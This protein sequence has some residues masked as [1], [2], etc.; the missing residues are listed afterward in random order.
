MPA[1]IDVQVS[2]SQGRVSSQSLAQ[3]SVGSQTLAA[4]QSLSPLQASPGLPVPTDAQSSSG[5]GRA[6]VVAMS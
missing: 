3:W 4:S 1:P 6:R 5:S 2:E